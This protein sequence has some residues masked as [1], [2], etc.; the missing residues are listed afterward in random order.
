ML[1]ARFEDAQFFY[2]SDLKQPLEDF[3]SKLAGTQFHKRLGNL[4]QKTER[5][6]QLV[7]PLAHACCLSG[8]PIY[9]TLTASCAAAHLI[10]ECPTQGLV[11]EV[12]QGTLSIECALNWDPPPPIS[13][14]ERLLQN[15]VYGLQML[16]RRQKV[17]RG[18]PELTWQHPL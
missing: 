18:C 14:F 11:L 13:S 7:S 17:Q 3:V 6:Q 5:V 10:P 8:A 9:K 2:N 15:G 12:A 4:L 1:Q 16:L